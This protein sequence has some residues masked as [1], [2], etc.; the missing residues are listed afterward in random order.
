MERR[1]ESD[2]RQRVSLSRNNRVSSLFRYA[3]CSEDNV[4]RCW[5]SN[6]DE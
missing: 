3:I 4:I 6:K 2:Y 1:V 5:L